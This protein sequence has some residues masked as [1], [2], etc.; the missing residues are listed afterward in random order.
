MIAYIKGTVVSNWND[1]LVIV[2]DS[3]VGYEVLIGDDLSSSLGPI[4]VF[5]RHVYNDNLSRD[6]LFGFATPQARFLAD[7]I[8]QKTDKVGYTIAHRIVTSVGA[9]DIQA[10]IEQDNPKLISS[11]V[12][13]LGLEKAKAVLK[14]IAESGLTE[15]LG[16][17]KPVEDERI[18][19]CLVGLDALGLPKSEYDKRR[20]LVIGMAA[21]YP[22]AS[23]SNLFYRVMNHA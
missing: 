13:G 19:A 8:E 4:E 23:P 5:C 3:G 12:K 18:K 20:G 15:T 22:E 6:V 16:L 14:T 1:R 21:A 10:A 9:S 2:T 17:T 7:L 11:K